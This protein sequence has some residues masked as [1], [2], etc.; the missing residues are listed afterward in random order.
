MIKNS[1]EDK[2]P[3]TYK[4]IN[5][6]KDVVAGK[7]LVSK[8]TVL[9]CKRF[10]NDMSREFMDDDCPFKFDF[11]K[12][13]KFLRQAQKFNHVKGNNWKTN[14]LEFEPWQCFIFAAIMGFMRITTGRRRFRNAFIEVPRGC[15]KHIWIEEK[16]PTPKGLV[17][18]SDIEIGDEL[19]DSNGE[20]CKVI[21]KTDTTMQTPIEL[22]FSN[23]EK[24]ISSD[25]HQWVT[26]T[27]LERERERDHKTNPVIRTNKNGEIV[28]KEEYSGVR[29]SKEILETLKTKNKKKPET[30]HSVKVSSYCG[31]FKMLPIPPYIFGMWLGNGT[32]GRN[33]IIINMDDADTI[34]SLFDSK[35]LS[36]IKPTNYSDGRKAVCVSVMGLG[37]KLTKLG[38]GDKEEK[39]IPNIYLTSSKEQRIELL[40]GIIDSDGYIS[41][42]GV[43]EITTIRDTLSLDIHY[44][45]S[46]LGFKCTTIKKPISK[47]NNYKSSTGYCWRICFTPRSEFKVSNL[48][49]KCKN[50]EGLQGT[51]TYTDKNYII[52]AKELSEKLPM[53]CVEVDSPDHTYLVSKSCIPT[54]NSAIASILGL[55][56]LALDGELGAEVLCASTKKDAARIVFDSSRAMAK[57]N[58]KFLKYTKTTVQQHQIK[59]DPTGGIMKPLS[60]DSKSQDGLNPNLIIGDEVHEWNHSLYGVL[61]SAMTKRDDSLFFMITTAGFNTDGI[62]FENHSYSEK[63]LNGTIEDD[64]WF[65][66]IYTIDEGDDWEK[67]ETWKK[68]NPNYGI[69]VDP[70]NFEAKCKKAK[71]TPFNKTNFLV[72]HLNQW[73][74]QA[75]PFFNLADWDACEDTE[76]KVEQ[77]FREKCMTGLDLAQKCDLVSQIYLFKKDGIYYAFDRSHIPEAKL[78]DERNI[79]LAK[80]KVEGWLGTHEGEVIDFEKIQN[81][82]IDMC[83]VQH[84]CVD[85]LYDPWS[86]NETGQR[87]M[88]ENISAKEFRMT[89][90]NLSEPMKKLDAL[91][92]SRKFRHNGSPL[93]RWC[94]G[95]VV[96]KPDA[97]ENV[98]PRKSHERLKIDL[99]VALF[100][101]LGGWIADGEEGSIYEE[102][103]IRVV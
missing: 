90:Q 2:Y 17:R 19:F 73:Q 68:A 83:K 103:G 65:T 82:V 14:N 4:G 97:N 20:V 51:H 34:I 99:A 61:D 3:F 72:K 5:Y 88:K 15:G 87:I 42:R 27:K 52:G 23:G 54:H 21:K 77:F 92:K 12:S 35:T 93:F 55:Y 67:E 56:F 49:R 94:I 47:N 66:T 25:V 53:F 76:L 30:N 64:T 69:S 74:N 18:W 86:A 40:R 84:D 8:L 22:E 26:S 85:V 45:I 58:P 37:Q 89:T 57:A 50:Q 16:V 1:R 39:R 71:E 63:I 36:E 9:S 60:S 29:S 78:A 75:S 62:G 95:N 59:H 32:C 96:A 38:L 48:P 13:E 79:N 33:S 100:M 91:L 41:D 44:L 7:I 80:W 101:A 10:L 43:V 31:R 81:D 70:I 102:R 46:S 24:I 28:R 98:F 11:E 6:A